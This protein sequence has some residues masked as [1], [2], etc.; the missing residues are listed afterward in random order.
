MIFSSVHISGQKYS[1]GYP[2]AIQT[3]LDWIANHDVAHMNVGT[4]EI[5]GRDLYINIQDIITKPVIECSAER[6]NNFLDIQYV[7]SGVERMG[8]MPYT[9]KEAVY[10]ALENKDIIIYKELEGENFIDVTPGCY[11]VFFPDDIHRP[12]CAVGKSDRVRKVVAK[13][14]YSLL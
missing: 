8:C 4:Y 12:G 6:H 5:Q 14:K 10:A 1:Y 2:I 11:C 3:A 7:V 13:I 9:G